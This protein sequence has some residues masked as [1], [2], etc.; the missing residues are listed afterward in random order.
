MERRV[1]GKCG[2]L[3]HSGRDPCGDENVLY[4]ENIGIKILVVTRAIV[5]EDVLSGKTGYRIY[6]YYFLQLCVTLQLFKIKS[7]IWKN[8]YI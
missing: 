1:G 2:W 8:I 7:I 5:L 3:K 6:L 4:L